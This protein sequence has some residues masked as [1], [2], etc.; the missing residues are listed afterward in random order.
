[1]GAITDS[2]STGIEGFDF[3]SMTVKPRAT[4]LRTVQ[5]IQAAA[6]DNRIKGIYINFDETVNVS[7]SSLEEIRAQL[8]KFKESGKF[9]VAYQENWGQIGYWF[10]SVAD[11]VYA[12][13][14]GDIRW[15]GL[16][17]SVM[18]YKGLLDKLDIEPVVVRHGSFKSAVEP[19]ILDKMSPE[20]RLQYEKMTGSLWSM[21]VSE[22]ASARGIAETDLQTWA[23]N[24]TIDSPRAAID[25]GMLDGVKYED[26]VMAEIASLMGEGVEKP[27][28]VSFGDYVSQVTSTNPTSK[29]KI[30]IV[31]AEGEIVSGKGAQ[32][33][34]GSETLV[35]KIREA[36]DDESTVAVVLRIN[37][38]GGSALAS[39]VM[40]RELELLKAEKPL[41]VSMGNL[42]AS[43]GYYIAA[44]ADAIY[45][46]RSTLT[47]SIGV[48]GLFPNVG[49]AFKNKLGITVD[50]VKTNRHADLGSM[51][52]TPSA[53][54][55][56]YLQNMVER[57]YSTFVGHVSAG[58]NMTFEAVDAVGQGRV[59]TGADALEIGLIDGYG[60]LVD[61]VS[62]AADRVQVGDDFRIWEVTGK[63]SPFDELFGAFS[64]SIRNW[65]LRDELGEAFGH[66]EYLRNVLDEGGIQARMPVVVEID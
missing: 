34:V 33:Q 52:R 66:Y 62:L 18:F 14:A 37:S 54:E 60:G 10:S 61:A 23:D 9:I 29:N 16:A 27:D 12:N 35:E 47:G 8:V 59:W 53:A 13:P 22:I 63:L 40:W 45:A 6:D 7:I 5:A 30:A 3:A 36:R 46:N 50:V 28:V 2:P 1:M 24:L 57:V 31:Y 38:P 64:T 20:N 44:P 65:V 41:I 17:A 19:F 32:G 43:G 15:T 55:M 26:E 42:A 58:R 51:Y 4:L 48:F 21:V 39:E 11:K 25:K 49:D 56:N